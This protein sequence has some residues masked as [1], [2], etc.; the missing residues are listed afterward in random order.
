MS[1]KVKASKEFKAFSESLLQNIDLNRFFL[2]L[3]KSYLDNIE[4]DTNKLQEL[5]KDKL[6][7]LDE[8]VMI[9]LRR[10]K[11]EIL[12]RWM[13]EVTLTRSVDD[14]DYYLSQMLL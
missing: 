3:I 4:P 1:G 9:W 6:Q 13:L 10:P 5:S 11:Y 12:L 7:G 8:N 14:F 2:S